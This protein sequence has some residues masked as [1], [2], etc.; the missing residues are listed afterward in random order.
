MIATP[1]EQWWGRRGDRKNAE[2]V[3]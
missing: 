3:S 2:A 1:V